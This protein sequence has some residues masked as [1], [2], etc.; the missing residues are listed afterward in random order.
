MEKQEF[1]AMFGI[2]FGQHYWAFDPALQ[3]ANTNWDFYEKSNFNEDALD[4]VKTFLTSAKK[5]Y[6][7][8]GQIQ[9]NR[10]EIR[11]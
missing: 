1:F 4:M 7:I 5:F 8:H 11:K 6:P 10:Y 9:P 3:L 2:Y